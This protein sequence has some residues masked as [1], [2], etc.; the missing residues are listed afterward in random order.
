MLA[1]VGVVQR[2]IIFL[3][4]LDEWVFGFTFAL[5]PAPFTNEHG[6]IHHPTPGHGAW[7]TDLSIGFAK[8][9][10]FFFKQACVL[11]T[12]FVV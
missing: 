12:Q 2:Y 10:F 7:G 5:I 1:S 9:F 8:A 3:F 11:I 4:L 6:D